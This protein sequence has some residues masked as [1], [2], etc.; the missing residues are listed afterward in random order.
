MTNFS[1]QFDYLPANKFPVV[2]GLFLFDRFSLAKPVNSIL[3]ETTTRH[4]I[5]VDGEYVA[6]DIL[7]TAGKVNIILF[8][9]LLRTLLI[10]SFSNDDGNGNEN[11][12]KQ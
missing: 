7:D 8:C 10:G 3:T 5:D 1:Y 4:H 12:T 6:L 11:A 9:T 2:L